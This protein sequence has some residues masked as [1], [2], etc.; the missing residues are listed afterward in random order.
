MS[1]FVISRIAYSTPSREFSTRPHRIRGT[2][3]IQKKKVV[4]EENL[5]SEIKVLHLLLFKYPQKE[6]PYVRYY[7]IIIE[8]T[9]Y[10]RKAHIKTHWFLVM[11]YS[12]EIEATLTIDGMQPVFEGRNK[13]SSSRSTETKKPKKVIA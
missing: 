12:R 11:G 2:V 9:S 4:G 6:R 1:A 5:S 10:L 13:A 7:S 8:S 3:R